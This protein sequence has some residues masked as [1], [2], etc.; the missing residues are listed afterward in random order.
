MF[1]LFIAESSPATV[2]DLSISADNPSTAATLLQK[3]SSS[4]SS[5]ENP[6]QQAPMGTKRNRMLQ[7]QPRVKRDSDS[8]SNSHTPDPPPCGSEQ[9]EN[10]S[11]HTATT[12][13]GVNSQNYTSRSLPPA[14]A[15]Q[16]HLLTVD[17]HETSNSFRPSSLTATSSSH[18]LSVPHSTH[19]LMKQ[20]SDPLLPTQ[21]ISSMESSSISGS[22]P[23]APLHRQY[24]HPLPGTSGNLLSTSSSG[25]HSHQH[26]SMQ[27]S[28]HGSS[29]PPPNVT[30]HYTVPQ[31]QTLHHS[32][33]DVI[34]KTVAISTCSTSTTTTITS[35]STSPT[36]PAFLQLPK[37]TT[38]Y[39][40]NIN[41]DT[42]DANCG[43]NTASHGHHSQQHG[44]T[45][46]SGTNILGHKFRMTKS[47]SATLMSDRH[48]QPSSSA[49]I[50]SSFEHVPTLRVKSEE[51]QRSVSSPQVSTVI[52]LINRSSI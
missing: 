51:L 19:V 34:S 47:A 25:L 21:H 22:N 14:H 1:I 24:S 27:E 13:S 30:S 46:N 7:R 6:N 29:S 43:E 4:E 18:F 10:L 33:V 49:M 26:I 37:F 36:T 20:H 3:Q 2:T 16:H 32:H 52:F 9:F 45:A 31:L 38:T 39:F 17:R 50:S 42:E 41:E 48:L 40:D 44:S 23:M 8:L 15:Q 28:L 11:S 5:A 35:S 12:G